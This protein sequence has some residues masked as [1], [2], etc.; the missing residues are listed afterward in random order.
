[1][2]LYNIFFKR[3]EFCLASD[4]IDLD[5]NSMFEIVKD[6]LKELPFFKKKVMSF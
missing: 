5:Y 4:A 2:N 3:K 6:I 1:M